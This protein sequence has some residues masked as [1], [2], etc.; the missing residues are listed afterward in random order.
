MCV[1][2]YIRYN[3]AV[4][5]LLYACICMCMCMCMRMRMRVRVHVCICVCV[6]VC[7]CV[8]LQLLVV[9]RAWNYL[10]ICCTND[11]YHHCKTN[12][13]TYRQH[14]HVAVNSSDGVCTA[15]VYGVCL[16]TLP[17]NTT[18]QYCVTL[19]VSKQL[20]TSHYT[21]VC[22]ENTVEPLYCGHHWVEKT[23]PHERGVLS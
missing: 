23:C 5:F 14:L 6:C 21:C 17:Y 12:E 7:M 20:V 10:G 8:T 2:G 15:L 3:I 13:C 22:N 4:Q 16:N 18:Q 9:N 1:F 11:C 19:S